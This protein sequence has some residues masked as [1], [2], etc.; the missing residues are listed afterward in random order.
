MKVTEVN[1]YESNDVTYCNGYARV[2]VSTHLTKC[3]IA[4]RNSLPSLMCDVS[5]KRTKVRRECYCTYPFALCETAEEYHVD[6]S[7]YAED[8]GSISLVDRYYIYELC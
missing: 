8:D 5:V 4:C 3:D 7:W 6:A 1:V 2:E